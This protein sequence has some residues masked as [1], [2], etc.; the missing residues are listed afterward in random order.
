MNETRA[1]AY[2]VTK[3]SDAVRAA[4]RALVGPGGPAVRLELLWPIAEH[5]DE[6]DRFR[7]PREGETPFVGVMLTAGKDLTLGLSCAPDGRGVNA[8]RRAWNTLLASLLASLAAEV[9]D[10]SSEGEDAEEDHEAHDT[11]PLGPGARPR[12]GVTR[13]S[14]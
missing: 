6:T 14:A 5:P 7:A 9:E 12:W 1:L 11:A 13:G 10:P 4:A 2:A 3:L 8:R